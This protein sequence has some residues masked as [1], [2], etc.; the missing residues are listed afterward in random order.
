MKKMIFTF[1]TVFAFTG[2]SVA[3]T[4]VIDEDFQAGIPSNWTLI[5]DTNTVDSTVLDF[6]NAWI[7]LTD[8]LDNT[9][10]VVGSTS[11]FED[12][13]NPAS[14]WLISPPV[15]LGSFGNTLTWK[16]RVHDPSFSDGYLVLLS[17]TD[18]Q[19]ASFNDTIGYI[20]QEHLAWTTRS[21]DLSDSTYLNQNVY[22]AFVNNSLDKFKLYL[23]DIQ[24]EVNNPV[25]VPIYPTLALS[26]YPNPLQT[27]NTIKCNETILYYR[28]TTMDGKLI[29]ENRNSNQIDAEFFP[30]G[31]YLLYVETAKGSAI[32]ALSK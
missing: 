14:R 12:Q 10:L 1:A 28:V 3:Q 9:N 15:T 16:A 26:V 29:A 25:S 8:P 31:M 30:K 23:D 21:V 27:I 24:L 6:S 11:F 2:I 5:N 4:L 32:Q 7:S 13:T 20:L 19:V 18:N 17:K 22:V